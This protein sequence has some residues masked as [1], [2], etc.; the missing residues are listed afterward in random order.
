VDPGFRTAGFAGKRQV[1]GM[2]SS[3]QNSVVINPE[4]PDCE[5]LEIED[6]M[7]IRLDP[8]LTDF[9]TR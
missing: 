9:R 4:R 2:G 5:L 8:R 6:G 1:S 7:P 3:V